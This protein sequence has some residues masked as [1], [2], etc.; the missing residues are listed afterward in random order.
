MIKETT[1]EQALDFNHPDFPGVET[2]IKRLFDFPYAFP[3]AHKHTFEVNFFQRYRYHSLNY[4][5]FT[6]FKNFLEVHINLLLPKYMQLYASESCVLNPFINYTTRTDSYT[7]SQARNK[8]YQTRY[9]NDSSH[10]SKADGSSVTDTGLKNN[11]SQENLL[12]SSDDINKK[13][14]TNDARSTKNDYFTDSPQ[15]QQSVNNEAF[16]DGYITTKDL[17]TERTAFID[18]AVTTDYNKKAQEQT[19]DEV[20]NTRQLTETAAEGEAR[21]YNDFYNDAETVNSHRDTVQNMIEESGI[22][23]VSV[24]AILNEWRTT[25]INVDKMFIDELDFLFMRVY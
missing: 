7:N 11:T 19:R 3:E 18:S 5:S 2:Y 6:M 13:K 23:G 15:S 12:S 20:Q 10:S 14:E 25:F 22:K 16:N 9:G 8:E 21:G 17:T 24:S 1:L 4:D